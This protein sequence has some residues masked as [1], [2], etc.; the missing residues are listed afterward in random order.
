MKNFFRKKF[1]EFRTNPILWVSCLFA[2]SLLGFHIFQFIDSGC[3]IEPLIR[4]VFYSACPFIIFFFGEIGI[5]YLVSILAFTTEQ[6]NSFTNYTSFFFLSMVIMMSGKVQKTIIVLVYILD[7]IIVCQN[8]DKSVIHLAIHFIGCAWIFLYSNEIIKKLSMKVAGQVK[9][10]KLILNEKE[11]FILSQLSKIQG[12][13]KWIVGAS[14]SMAL[15]N[16]PSIF[17]ELKNNK[18]IKSMNVIDEDDQID[19]EKIY[20]Y[21]SEQA[22]KSA[23][24]F[25]MPFIGAVTIKASDLD[26]LYQLI[27]EN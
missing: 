20:K 25:N 1:Y 6:F 22:K 12:L 11:R 26:K 17:N 3:R 16:G 27:M 4:V 10:N 24:T 19:V 15:E 21:L 7:V 18:I 5:I 2:V 14:L 8:Y 9:Q 23:V 13:N